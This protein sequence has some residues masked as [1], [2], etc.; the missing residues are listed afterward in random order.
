MLRAIHIRNFR[1]L[2]DNYVQL[3]SNFHVLVGRNGTAKTTFLSAIDLV[4]SV[5]RGGAKDALAEFADSFTDLCFV[6]T[7]S[8]VSI[9]IEFEVPAPVRTGEPR[10]TSDIAQ[11][12][13]TPVQFRYELELGLGPEGKSGLR[14]LHEGLFKLPNDVQRLPNLSG[15]DASKHP[16]IHAITS[17]PRNWTP[18]LGKVLD[19][20]AHFITSPEGE[21][22]AWRPRLEHSAFATLPEA[23]GYELH[24]LAHEHLANRPQVVSLDLRRL[25]EPCIPTAS[26]SFY[27]DGSNLP[28]VL[29]NF[30]Q[31][32]PVLYELW[33]RHVSQAVE[34][35]CS[36]GVHEDPR[37]KFLSVVANFD[38]LHDQ[39]V[40][41][42][43]LSEGTL[44]LIG[45]T[46]LGFLPSDAH[47]RLYMIE[48]PEDGLH[49]LA[50][51][52]V[53]SALTEPSSEAQVLLSSH[54]PVL[55]A[56][57]ALEQVLVFQRAPEG[58]AVICHGHELPVLKD[59]QERGV[60]MAHL[61]ASGILS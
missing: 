24:W 31:S 44:K 42:A 10:E 49:P 47:P 19:G 37:T 22:T 12:A 54:S 25:K 30:K 35:L 4:A 59:W 3:P 18:L 21:R 53:V 26:S 27:G 14:V 34:G 13:S 28:K 32:D 15:K 52:T 7:E 1:M 55:L 60:D 40:P 45:L 50:M 61:L 29:Q 36:I 17:P 43:L 11:V 2:A 5:I 41:A 38:G 6:P 58:Y 51:E 39:P 23:E 8:R 46:L 56:Q 33:E 20:R 9:A 57:V 48:Q 16:V